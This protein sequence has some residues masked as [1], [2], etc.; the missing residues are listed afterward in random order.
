MDKILN[1]ET[2]HADLQGQQQSQNG[3]SQEGPLPRALLS[4]HQRCVVI[5]MAE[6]QSM[7]PKKVEQIKEM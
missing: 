4:D 2:K 7:K 3:S 1:T 5:K 6:M